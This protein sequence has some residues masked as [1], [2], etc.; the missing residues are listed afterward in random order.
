M[1]Q[2]LLKR[3][4]YLQ[5]MMCDF[6]TRTNWSNIESN[7]FVNTIIIF[8][9][10]YYT[11]ISITVTFV[12]QPTLC[13]ALFSFLQRITHTSPVPSSTS[14]CTY[15]IYTEVPNSTNKLNHVKRSAVFQNKPVAL[16]DSRINHLCHYW[17][18]H[19]LTIVQITFH[20]RCAWWLPLVDEK[21]VIN[22]SFAISIVVV[23]LVWQTMLSSPIALFK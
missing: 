22:E 9:L 13:H 8:N 11:N 20:N 17:N 3:L 6:V 18:K 12:N 10:S 23:D 4:C 2:P 5:K 16:P 19:M 7:Y 14:I 1:F 21:F 15:F